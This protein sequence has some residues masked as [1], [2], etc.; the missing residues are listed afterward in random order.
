MRRFLNNLF[1]NFRTTSSAPGKR[2][3]ALQVEG[4]EDRMMPAASVNLLQAVPVNNGSAV[5]FV[6]QSGTLFERTPSGA[7]VGLVVA[8][9]QFSAG[10]D[11][12]GNADVFSVSQ[13][14]FFMEENS[15][16]PQ[17]LNAPVQIKEFA[18]AHGD[19]VYVVGTDESLWVHSPPFVVFGHVFGGWREIAGPGQAQYVDAVTQSSGQDALFVV[20]GNGQLQECINGVFM[21]LPG[22]DFTPGPNFFRFATISAGLD[23]NGNADVFGL[24]TGVNHAELWRWTNNSQGWTELGGVNQFIHISA[25][26]NGQVFCLTFSGDLDKFDAQNNFQKLYSNAFYEVAAA[27]SNDVYVADTFDSSL[28]EL[29]NSTTWHEVE[30]PNSV[31]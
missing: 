11:R 30:G 4:L 12:S 7:K 3:A 25:T 26:N 2:R 31:L 5:F 13:N 28:W 23:L 1:R 9:Q 14:N 20:R 29:T 15:S 6:N 24:S 8:V 10:V 27:S 21:G 22:S 16:G 18:A 17:A 19:R